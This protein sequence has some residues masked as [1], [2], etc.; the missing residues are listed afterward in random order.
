MTSIGFNGLI[1]SIRF[2]LKRRNL[3]MHEPALQFPVSMAE[4]EQHLPL[5]R[6]W[7]MAKS[8]TMAHLAQHT[9][10]FFKPGSD[11]SN[12]APS[13]NQ[14]PDAIAFTKRCGAFVTAAWFNLINGKGLGAFTFFVVIADATG[15]S[16][17]TFLAE[18]SSHFST[19]S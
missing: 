11:P 8:D 15:M 10:V 19:S 12:R 18:L 9:T 4:M 5:T 2:L 14:I 16:L 1:K 13:P 3:A 7:S 6:R 17:V